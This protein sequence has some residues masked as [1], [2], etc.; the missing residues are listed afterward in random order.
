MRSDE[1]ACPK[2]AETIKVKAS[3]CKHCRHQ[4]GDDDLAAANEAMVAKQAKKAL[5][6]E[7]KDVSLAE[8]LKELRGE[9]LLEEDAAMISRKLKIPLESVLARARTLGMELEEDDNDEVVLPSHEINVTVDASDYRAAN[10]TVGVISPLIIAAFIA[11]L[12][13][14]G[15]FGY[16]VILMISTVAFYFFV[17]TYYSHQPQSLIQSK[18]TSFARSARYRGFGPMTAFMVFLAIL[19]WW[20]LVI[21]GAPEY[22]S[23]LQRLCNRIG[24]T[25]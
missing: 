14:Q 19:V 9:C 20:L 18:M 1:R 21:Q 6:K 15:I 13:G 10:S 3:V 8:T 24:R 12:L 22:Q 17:E 11:I 4:F 2:C 7:L 16:L 23:P 25:C 5:D